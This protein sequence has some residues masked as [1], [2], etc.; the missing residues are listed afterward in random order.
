M[1]GRIT[2][3]ENLLYI[4]NLYH[5][6]KIFIGQPRPSIGFS[7][8]PTYTDCDCDRHHCFVHCAQ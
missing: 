6:R 3:T 2:F 8:G 5:G 1:A 7:Y 4:Y